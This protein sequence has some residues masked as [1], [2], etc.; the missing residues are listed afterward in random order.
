MCCRERSSNKDRVAEKKESAYF[1]NIVF[2]IVKRRQI[3]DKEN[4][5]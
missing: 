3:K 1:L 5:K 2:V 4:H